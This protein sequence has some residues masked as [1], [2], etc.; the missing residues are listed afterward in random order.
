MKMGSSEPPAAKL[1][2]QHVVKAEQA[3]ESIER[4]NARRLP[5]FLEGGKPTN[6]QP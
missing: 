2:I 1:E 3:T 5:W 6:Q 4:D